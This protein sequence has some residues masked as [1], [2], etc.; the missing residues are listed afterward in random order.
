MRWFS[1]PGY[2]E[3]RLLFERAL[4]AIYLIA[5]VVA[6]NQFRALLGANGILPIRNFVA[7]VPFNRA[8]SIFHWRASDAL[9]E[10]VT[11]VGA[12]ASAALLVGVV[13]RAPLWT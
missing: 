11:M 1:A 12:V 8:P 3:S 5:F 13:D 10:T 7:R 9:F 6:R 4:A 2:W